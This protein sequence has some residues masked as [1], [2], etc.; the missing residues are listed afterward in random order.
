MA[1]EF[2]VG[3]HAESKG[4]AAFGHHRFN[5]FLESHSFNT[6]FCFL[7]TETTRYVFAFLAKLGF[8][9]LLLIDF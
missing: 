7:D 5:N 3:T 2:G 8:R 6:Q 4:A 1:M 9:S